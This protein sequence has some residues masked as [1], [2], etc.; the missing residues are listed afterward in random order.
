MNRRLFLWLL[1]IAFI[2]FLVSHFTE[3]EKLA[4]TLAQGKWEWVLVAF[5]VQGVYFIVFTASYQAAFATV[6]VKSRVRDLLPVLFG[7]IFV[8]VVVPSGGTGGA[9]LFVDD[10][11][12]RGQQPS[13]AATGLLLQLVSD[14]GAFTL[15]LAIGMVY[16]FVQH[17]LKIYEVIT[18]IILMAITLGL[19]GIITLGLWR[20]SVLRRLLD[21]FQK[22]VNR[23]ALRLKRSP[24]LA[25]GWAEKNAGEFV[26]AS[27]AI[28]RHPLRLVRTLALTLTAHLL[29]ILTLYF[30]FLAFGEPIQIGPLVAGYAMGILFWIVS[31]TPQG[32]GVVEGVMALV[33]TA[34]HVPPAVATTVALAFR[35]LTFWLPFF[36]GFV[37]L[38]RAKTFGARERS[39]TE[40]WQVRIVALFTAL[41]GIL[42]VLSAVTPTLAGRAAVLEQILPLMVRGGGHLTAALA[43]FALLLLA[44]NLARRKRAAW[45]LTMAMLIISMFSH[46]LKGLDYEEALLALGLAIWLWLLRYHF[47]ARSDRLSIQQ[48]LKTLLWAWVFTIAYGVL[49]FYLLDKHF[50]VNFGFWDALR[51]TVVMFTEFYNP[52]LEPVTGF[53]RY[54]ADSIYFVGAATT[55]YA[56]LMILRPVLMRGHAS[57]EERH[58]ASVIVQAY[59]CSSLA[60]FTLLDDK[61][62]YFSPGG[63]LI[64]YAF[65]QRVGLALGDPIGPAE[66]MPGAIVGFSEYC[67]QNDWMPA[68]Y[69]TLPDH[70]EHYRAA[71]F[72]VLCIGQEGIV[73]LPKF[74]LEGKASKSYRSGYS[75]LMKEGYRFEVRQ[76]PIAPDLLAELRQISDEWLTMMHG[77]EKRFSLGWFDD[78]YIRQAPVA[79]VFTPEGQISAFAN[80]VPE[81]QLNETTIDLMRRR[82]ESEAGMMDFL[83]VSLFEW[84]RQQGYATFDLGL[85]ALSG[86]GENPQDPAVERIMHFIYEHINQFYNFKGLHEFKD[87]FHP[88][89]SPRYLIY[90]GVAN[91]AQVWL[92][93]SVADSG[94]EHFPWGYFKR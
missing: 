18:A 4:E 73:D 94:D 43:G 67:Q 76:P 47:H 42:N 68:F 83:F 8:N 33:Y 78:D 75:R 70:L 23:V 69:Q 66:D 16:L 72:D 79:L 9:A 87:K 5:V 91:L 15:I 60:R 53:G 38:T 84:A 2:W 62:C 31:I 80:I 61:A 26:D 21:W 22:L 13:R 89:W 37:L 24:F 59:G 34:L 74:T 46:L 82:R 25:E 57:K 40:N 52:G 19:T 35:G 64:A 56:L 63:S 88:Q 65:S 27:T 50:S 36:I 14:Y 20:P 58:K 45:Y 51:Q 39:M 41:M 17:D 77:S 12:R 10:A 71:G 86:I 11:A 32:I 81:Y 49:G 3:V 1:V 48:G 54:F 44:G 30:L 92:A 90:P 28:L 55:G 6:E 7:S 93:L 85:S 29:D